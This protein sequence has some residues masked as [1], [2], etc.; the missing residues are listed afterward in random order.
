MVARGGK[1]YEELARGIKVGAYWRN[2]YV[3]RNQGRSPIC[4]FQ[5]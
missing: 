5:Q 1:D 2:A 4:N 3:D